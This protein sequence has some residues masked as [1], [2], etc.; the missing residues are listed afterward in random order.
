LYEPQPEQKTHDDKG[1]ITKDL[2]VAQGMD[3]GYPGPR[4]F[5]K[6]VFGEY[7]QD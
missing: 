3:E 5:G 4:W 6:V 1:G 7:E 2:G